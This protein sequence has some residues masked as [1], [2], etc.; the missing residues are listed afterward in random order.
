MTTATLPAT[1]ARHR[2]QQMEVLAPIATA[3]A[4]GMVWWI[5]GINAAQEARSAV[6]RPGDQVTSAQV[7]AATARL[8]AASRTAHYTAIS[9]SDYAAA[10]IGLPLSSPE[11]QIA[12]AAAA[13]AAAARADLA[14][15]CVN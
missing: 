8:R 3:V 14:R 5:G 11:H 15:L 1:T 6:C 9:G 10:K 4:T 7:Q 13:E 2:F 12:L